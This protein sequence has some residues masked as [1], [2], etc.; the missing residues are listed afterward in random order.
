MVH[1]VCWSGTLL[2]AVMVRIVECLGK[3]KTLS[4][5]AKSA[6]VTYEILKGARTSLMRA[7]ST[8]RL[9]NFLHNMFNSGKAS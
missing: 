7:C 1:D 6:I 9:L 5:E 2:H 4:A 8:Q 3:M